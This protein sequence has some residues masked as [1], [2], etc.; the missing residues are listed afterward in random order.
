M[1]PQVQVRHG[2]TRVVLLLG[3]VAIKF[4]TTT[5]WRLFL[6]GLLANMT[7]ARFGRM[8]DARFREALC[9]VRFAVPGGWLIVMSRATPL[10]AS[11]YDERLVE[12]ADWPVP[13]EPKVDSVGLLDGRVVAVDYGN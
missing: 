1:L 3:G 6:Q 11:E 9:P 7:E 13:I 12:L 2:T 8:D 4:P 10:T 5:S